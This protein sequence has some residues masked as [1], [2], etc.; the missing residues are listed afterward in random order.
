MADKRPLTQDELATAERLRAVWERRKDELKTNQKRFA[1]SLGMTQSAFSQYLTAK[2]PLGIGAALEIAG[3]LGVELAEINPK[4][5]S[6]GLTIQPAKDRGCISWH[7][8]IDAKEPF[9]LVVEDSSMVDRNGGPLNFH[10]G[11]IIS[12]EPFKGKPEPEGLYLYKLENEE[13]PVFGQHW[14]QERGFKI[15]FFNDSWAD[16]QVNESNPGKPIASL[17]SLRYTVTTK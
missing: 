14:Q 13:R 8:A 7:E 10:P 6:P 4:W 15:H 9:E 1:E 12:L 16:I 11:Y 2:I 5:T 17:V 3:G